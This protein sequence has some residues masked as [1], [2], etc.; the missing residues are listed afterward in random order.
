MEL[1]HL[2]YIL[3]VA[4]EAH[5]TA[6]AERLGIQQPP[7]S[8]LLK[9]VERELGV[10]LF[11][12]KPRGVELTEAGAAFSEGARMVLA[13]LESTME[14]ARSISRGEQGKL[15]IGFTATS[16]F[17]PLTAC[18]LRQFRDAYPLVEV[19]CEENMSSQ[20][21]E[22]LRSGQIDAAFMWSPPVEGLIVNRLAEEPLFVAI[23]AQSALARK[24]SPGQAVAIRE[25]AGENFII[26]GRRDGFGLY[27][28]TIMACRAANFTPRFTS[29]N[30]RLS[31]ALNLV[32]I[33]AGVFFVPSSVSRIHMEGVAYRPLRGPGRPAATL[34]LATRRTN[35]SAVVRHFRS[36]VRRFAGSTAAPGIEPQTDDR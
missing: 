23:P 34:S 7:L 18:A 15:R 14:R 20:L 21:V 9:S 2:R 25:L 5:I 8:R 32:S 28:A 1:R 35:P 33:G 10:Q 3:A 13:Q 16:A 29:E 30:P 6:A 26:Y 17:N 4:E 12:R 31:G 11:V 22:R 19:T 24:H 36:S 27:A